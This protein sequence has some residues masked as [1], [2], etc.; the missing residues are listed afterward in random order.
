MLSVREHHSSGIPIPINMRSIRRHL[1]AAA[2]SVSMG[3]EWVINAENPTISQCLWPLVG[4]VPEAV[5]C[6]PSPAFQLH[7]HPMHPPECRPRPTAAPPLAS[8]LIEHGSPKVKAIGLQ[9]KVRPS[10]EYK[11][12][13]R[14]YPRPQCR[15]TATGFFAVGPEI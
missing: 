11:H 14:R 5:D 1:A 2:V 12:T 13:H 4:L 10:L 3:D 9:M 8:F 7:L 6:C 15:P